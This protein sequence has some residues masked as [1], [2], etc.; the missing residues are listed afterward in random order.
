M[1]PGIAR[2]LIRGIL[3]EAEFWAGPLSA[4]ASPALCLPWGPDLPL[5]EHQEDS[6]QL[7]LSNVGPTLGGTS[8]PLPRP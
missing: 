4:R 1:G 6:C 7:I 2:L 3:N 5:Q 8:S